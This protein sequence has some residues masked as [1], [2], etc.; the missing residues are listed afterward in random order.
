MTDGSFISL[1]FV[2][3]DQVENEIFAQEIVM[4]MQQLLILFDLHFEAALSA[5]GI[6]HYS[7]EPFCTFKGTET[8]VLRK[9]DL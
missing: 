7:H 3:S 4:F 9:K 8:T 1:W 6:G 2:H 5:R